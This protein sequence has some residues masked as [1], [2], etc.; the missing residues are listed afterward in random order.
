MAV[1][2]EPKV[3][4]MAARFAGLEFASHLRWP[5]RAGKPIHA[6]LPWKGMELG[7]KAMSLMLAD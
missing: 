4:V 1:K 7:L 6:G 3:V 5:F 2:A